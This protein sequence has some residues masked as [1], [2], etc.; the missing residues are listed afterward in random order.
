LFH[1]INYEGTKNLIDAAVKANVNH[2]VLISAA[3]AAYKIRTTYGESKIKTEEL[4]SHK[5]GSTNFTIIRPTLLYGHG[6][7]QELKIYVEKLRKFPLIIPTIGLLRSKKRPVWVND[8]VYGLSKLVNNP[9]AYGKIYNFGGATEMTMWQYTKLI[10]R[11]F[12]IKKI[13]VPI[14]VFICNIFA[15]FCEKYQKDPLLKRDFILGAIM[16]ANGEIGTAFDDLDYRPV[17]ISVGYPRAFAKEE[18]KF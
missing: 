1:K 3:A 15:W 12:G 18:D 7:S 16:D 5:R 2:F 9:K 8:I 6:G 17:D 11:T 13:M 10:K 4:V 14:P